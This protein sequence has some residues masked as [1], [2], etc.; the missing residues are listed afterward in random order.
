MIENPSLDKPTSGSI[1]FNTDSSR[2]EIYNGEAWWEIDA[3]SPELETGGVRGIFYAGGTPSIDNVIQFVNIATTGD[4]IDFGDA[5]TASNSHASFASRTRGFKAGGNPS[6]N[7]TIEFVTI[8]STGNGTDFGDLLEH[9]KHTC[10]VSNST[11]GVIGPGEYSPTPRVNVIEYVTMSSSGNSI[12]FG[13]STNPNQIGQNSGLGSPTRGIFAGGSTPSTP[14]VN[15]IDYITI[16]TTGNA[17]DFGDLQSAQERVGC[18]SNAVRGLIGTG[19]PS[20]SNLIQFLTIATLGDT[21]DFGDSLSTEYGKAAMSSPTRGVF[22]SSIGN[23]VDEIEYVQIMTRGN[24]IDFGDLLANRR[25]CSGLSNGHGG[26][27]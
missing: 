26:L 22:G 19:A 15:V 23:T 17:S 7:D 12:D 8:A 1:R 6:S 10:G 21:L 27:G 2:L 13:D 24:A 3:T 14:E 16:S 11:R 20:A 4:A 25:R 5:V 9:K 18:C